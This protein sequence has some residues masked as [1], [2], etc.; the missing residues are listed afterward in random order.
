MSDGSGAMQMHQV[1]QIDLP[2]GKTTKLKPGG[3]HIMLFDLASQLK[4]GQ[5]FR[6]TLQFEVGKNKT[7]KVTV[8]K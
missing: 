2:A 4:A 1:D 5:T 8:K 7:V 6:L 3:Y